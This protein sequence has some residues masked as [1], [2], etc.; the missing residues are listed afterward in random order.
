MMVNGD[1]QFPTGIAASANEVGERRVEKSAS[2]Y[3]SK[4]MSSSGVYDWD[5]CHVVAHGACFATCVVFA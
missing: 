2:T 1:F 5:Y 4:Y 3:I